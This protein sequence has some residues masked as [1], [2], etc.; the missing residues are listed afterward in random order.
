M[1]LPTSYPTQQ[2]GHYLPLLSRYV[3]ELF[4]QCSWTPRITIA[5]IFPL[6]THNSIQPL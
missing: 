5:H 6:Q 1:P 4:Y 3:N 2:V